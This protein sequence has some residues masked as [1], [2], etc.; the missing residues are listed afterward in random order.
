M[1]N[2]EQKKCLGLHDR[3]RK[4]YACKT[5]FAV[6][7]TEMFQTNTFW[8]LPEHI[9][10]QAQTTLVEIYGHQALILSFI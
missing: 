10:A 9:F 3:C 5:V 7:F 1:S 8:S 4:L 6:L 2:S